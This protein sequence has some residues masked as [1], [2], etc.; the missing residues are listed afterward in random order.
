MKAHKS[1]ERWTSSLLTFDDRWII[2]YSF[3]KNKVK[4]FFQPCQIFVLF[5]PR[6]LIPVTNCLNQPVQ[7]LTHF[8]SGPWRYAAQVAQIG[9]LF[10]EVGT[11]N[12]REIKR[13]WFHVVPGSYGYREKLV[14]PPALVSFTHQQS[15]CWN[16]NCYSKHLISQVAIEGEGFFKETPIY[17]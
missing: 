7:Q 3:T 11:S 8:P 17:S 10:L 2:Q 4:F 6:W 12:A 16:S 15:A 13:L 9:L 14:C 5:C 1:R